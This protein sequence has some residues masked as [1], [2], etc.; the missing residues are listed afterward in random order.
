M[1]FLPILHLGLTLKCG[2]S[3]LKANKREYFFTPSSPQKSASQHQQIYFIV[4]KP[5]AFEKDLAG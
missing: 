1:W 5:Y 4:D 3:K 2:G